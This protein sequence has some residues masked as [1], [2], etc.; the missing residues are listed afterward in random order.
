MVVDDSA[1]VRGLVSRWVDED[2]DMETVGRFANGQLALSGIVN[3]APDVVILDIEM[4]VMDGMTALPELLKLKPG[5]KIIIASTLSRKN[6][7]ISLKALSLG[8]TD[9][10]PKP[11]TNRGIT[12]SQEFRSELLRKV[13]AMVPRKGSAPLQ[14]APAESPLSGSEASGTSGTVAP[15]AEG[16][17]HQLRAFSPVK[18]RILGIGSST[19]GPQALAKVIE[20]LAPA[21]TDIPVVIT[22]HMPPTFTAILAEH[23]ARSSGRTAKEGE[24]GENVVPGTIYVAPGGLHMKLVQKDGG[25]VLSVYDGPMINYCKPAVDPLFESL[26][27]IYG[28]AT[29]ALVLTGM[30]HDGAAGAKMIADAGGSVIAQDEATSVVWGMPGATA[31]AGAC[32]AILPLDEIGPKASTVLR[33]GI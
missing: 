13:K 17:S 18:P 25:P 5:V 19:G 27:R 7:E 16:S 11:E 14:R 20:A 22:Q 30:G 3:A 26:V 23:L 29:L 8:A 24:D 32:A 33:G 2:T 4:P 31:E 9:Y 21:T 1:V 10:I 28:P 15:V 12:T 6:A